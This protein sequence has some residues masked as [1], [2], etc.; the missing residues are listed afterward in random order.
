MSGTLKTNELNGFSREASNIATPTL[1][2]YNMYI[3]LK[4]RK[5][6][7]RQNGWSRLL[8]LQSFICV[9]V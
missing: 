8:P 4:G 7:F 6:W 2:W 5:R 1:P 9:L 3:K